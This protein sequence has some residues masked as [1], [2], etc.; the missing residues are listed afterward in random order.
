[1]QNYNRDVQ[2]SPIANEIKKA[3]TDTGHMVR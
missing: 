1:M 3:F 2:G